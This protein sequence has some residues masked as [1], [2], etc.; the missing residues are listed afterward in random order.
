MPEYLSDTVGGDASSNDSIDIIGVYGEDAVSTDGDGNACLKHEATHQPVSCAG[1]GFVDLG[2]STGSTKECGVLTGFPAADPECL[3]ETKQQ[4]SDLVLKPQKTV[5]II[6]KD[7]SNAYEDASFQLV[8]NGVQKG[9]N[10]TGGTFLYK[11]KQ[12]DEDNCE[13]NSNWVTFAGGVKLEAHNESS[14]VQVHG[15]IQGV[16]S[17]TNEAL[18]RVLC[19]EGSVSVTS[20]DGSETVTLQQGESLV[21]SDL[22]SFSDV[23]EQEQDYSGVSVDAGASADVQSSTTASLGDPVKYP[24][25]PSG[26]CATGGPA[27][28]V[29]A[30]ILGTVAVGMAVKRGMSR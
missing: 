29:G 2:S 24:G 27:S 18:L 15:D 4:I 8:G 23:K 19:K 22:E 12:V 16:I 21:T 26:G 14:E 3:A 7:N 28:P 17:E 5:S 1:E 9:V 25:V 11:A 13:A 20:R 10:V 6:P 30:L